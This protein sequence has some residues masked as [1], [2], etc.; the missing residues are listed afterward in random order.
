MD[1]HRRVYGLLPMLCIALGITACATARTEPP[2][3]PPAQDPPT[4]ACDM[5]AH[6]N[7]I[8][9]AANGVCKLVAVSKMANQGRGNTILWRAA[10][11]QKTVRIEL[12]DPIFSFSCTGTDHVCR[13]GDVNAAVVGNDHYVYFYRAWICDAGAKN[14]Q[15]V[16]DPGII[17][18]P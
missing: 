13:S 14:C 10:D 12:D 2:P 18:R 16:I 8:D 7:V 9:V 6:D 17:I 4:T 11:P 1:L 5:K 3:P 15:E